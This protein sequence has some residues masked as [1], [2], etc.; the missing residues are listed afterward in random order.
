[1]HIIDN[2]KKTVKESEQIVPVGAIYSHFRNK[3]HLYK[4]L[5][6]AIDEKTEKPCVV[7]QALYGDKLIWVRPLSVWCESV[8]YE[9]KTVLRFQIKNIIPT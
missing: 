2:F 9:G 4:V 8:E 5:A 7:Y 1:M 3:E 6:I